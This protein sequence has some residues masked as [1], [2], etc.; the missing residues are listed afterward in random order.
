[1]TSESLSFYDL[2]RGEQPGW[3]DLL[4]VQEVADYVGADIQP[5]RAISSSEISL[6]VVGPILDEIGWTE[7]SAYQFRVGREAGGQNMDHSKYPTLIPV[8]GVSLDADF[9][10]VENNW[11]AREPESRDYPIVGEIKEAEAT[12][13]DQLLQKAI[14]D[15]SRYVRLTRAP[16]GIVTNGQYIGVVV[17][18]R[19]PKQSLI[20]GLSVEEFVEFLTPDNLLDTSW[21]T[22]MMMR[23]GIAD[24]EA[25]RQEMM[26]EAT[27][28]TLITH[29]PISEISDTLSS[30]YD[31]IKSDIDAL[32]DALEN[33]EF[34]EEAF[35]TWNQLR[36]NMPDTMRQE[37]TFIQESVYDLTIKLLTLKVTRDY[38]LIQSEDEDE[39]VYDGMPGTLRNYV[40]EIQGTSAV[41]PA[42]GMDVLSWWLPTQEQ[43]DSLTDAQKDEVEDRVGAISGYVSN[44][45]D[46]L[47]QYDTTELDRDQIGYI[48][49][50]HLPA[51]RRRI[52]GEYYTPVKIVDNILAELGY[53]AI[54]ESMR[55][56]TILDSSCGSGTFLVRASRNLRA[57]LEL[58]EDFQAETPEEANEALELIESNIC[59]LDINPFAVTL[60]EIN[61]FVTNIDLI[62]TSNREEVSFNVYATDSLQRGDFESGPLTQFMD[63]GNHRAQKQEE[64]LEGADEVK[65]MNHDYVVGNPPHTSRFS[66]AD[67][68][69]VL[70][71]Y[72]GVD[73]TATAFWRRIKNDFTASDGK[74]GLVMPMDFVTGFDAGA[75][76]REWFQNED[77][78][79]EVVVIDPA[80][81][82][83]FHRDSRIAKV[84]VICQK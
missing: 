82:E 65:D 70:D 1:V 60:A 27:R 44:A 23:S 84:S 55:N 20:K 15:V 45:R 7:D 47:D 30:I 74:I 13:P 14:T 68:S 62:E 66:P 51:E 2:N 28:Q 69:N 4:H 39:Y 35:G 56:K 19:D 11:R 8:N 64:I 16:I 9:V 80:Y 72:G 63:R 41:L 57:W 42:L 61:L 32:W 75:D 59:G 73:N 81:Y 17:Q 76:V 21:R 3:D 54:N 40:S 22:D 49:E 53:G 77:K 78:D 24:P 79:M 25:R 10:L 71:I 36:S 52:M 50:R 29:R 83:E 38:D 37:D 12:S 48:Y 58:R 67:Y 5:D 18:L 46:Q 33:T 34:V 6:R 31:Q 26:E 43:Y